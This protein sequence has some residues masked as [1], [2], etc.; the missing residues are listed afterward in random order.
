M[1]KIIL[2][3]LLLLTACS[4]SR[5]KKLSYLHDNVICIAWNEDTVVKYYIAI[6]NEHTFLY[7]IEDTLGNQRIITTYKGDC[8]YSHD[9][10]Y[11]SFKG[12]VQDPP[13]RDFMIQASGG[14]L[15]QQ[16]KDRRKIMYLR[17]FG[18]PAR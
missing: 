3:L 5:G 4:G 6:S 14:Y 2:P 9:T 11:L 15:S 1:K 16:F 18:Q 7:T 13:M 12:K 17:K 8:S 10:I